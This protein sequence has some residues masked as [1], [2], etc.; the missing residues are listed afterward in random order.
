MDFVCLLFVL[1]VLFLRFRF[2]FRFL[3]C[4]EYGILLR[5]KLGRI[6]CRVISMRPNGLVRRILV[7]ARS[8]FTR[9]VCTRAWCWIRESSYREC[10]RLSAVCRRRDASFSMSAG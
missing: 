2:S 4:L 9:T 6:R 7:R 8:R 5:F 3:L 10:D 1:F